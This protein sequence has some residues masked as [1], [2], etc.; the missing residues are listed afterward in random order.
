MDWVTNS[1]SPA[2]GGQKGTISKC[3]LKKLS[4]APTM[5]PGLCLSHGERN[6]GLGEALL[7]GSSYC[8]L[9]SLMATVTSWIFTRV[10]CCVQNCSFRSLPL[11]CLEADLK[12]FDRL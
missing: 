3:V 10:G 8:E 5:P 7:E 12:N 2:V 1:V 4:R 9:R 6:R 11:L